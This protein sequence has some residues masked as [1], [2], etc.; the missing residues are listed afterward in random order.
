[1]FWRGFDLPDLVVVLL[2]D[3]SVVAML[4]LSKLPMLP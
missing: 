2:C 1:M 3:Y 4:S